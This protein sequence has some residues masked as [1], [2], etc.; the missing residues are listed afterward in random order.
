MHSM[1]FSEPDRTMVIT[2]LRI[3]GNR[4]ESFTIMA[5]NPFELISPRMIL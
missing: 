2:S 5:L 4:R 3:H 1:I